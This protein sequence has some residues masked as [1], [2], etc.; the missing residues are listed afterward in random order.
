MVLKIK[1]FYYL[2][3]YICEETGKRIKDI[4]KVPYYTK[5]QPSKNIEFY[6]KAIKTKLN[7]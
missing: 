2:D 5:D 4:N 1:E 3:Y 6:K 7:I